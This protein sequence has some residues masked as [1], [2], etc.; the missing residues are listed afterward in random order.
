[1][2]LDSSVLLGTAASSRSSC[3]SC[4]SVNGISSLR[5]EQL[6]LLFVFGV[7]ATGFFSFIPPFLV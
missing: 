6:F 3:A 5:I 7:C 4:V 1:M 2:F